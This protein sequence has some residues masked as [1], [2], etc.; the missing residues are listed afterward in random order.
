M[1]VIART[2]LLDLLNNNAGMMHE[3]SIEE[4]SLEDWQRNLNLNLI[5]P[6]LLVREALP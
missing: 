1:Q 2:E 4:T 3:A 6:F 5:A